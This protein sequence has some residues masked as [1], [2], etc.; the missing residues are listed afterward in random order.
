MRWQLDAPWFGGWSGIEVTDH[1]ARMTVISDFGYILNAS[2]N[3]ASG[4]LDG[5]A[6]QNVSR[7]GR[8]S[9]RPLRKKASDAEG[10]AIS[11]D[12]TAYVSFEHRHRIM[13]VDPDTG[14][15]SG[16][17]ALPFQNTLGDN[18]GVEALAISADGT[19]FAIAENPPASGG[20]FP[21]YAYRNGKWRISA[22]IPQRGPF[23]PV[24]A[25]FDDKGRYW[26]LERATTLL[27]FRSRIRMFVIDPRAPREVSLL[28]TLPGLY[29]NLEGLS[30]WTDPR[31]QM[32]VTMISDDNYLRI[33]RTQIVEYTVNE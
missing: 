11:D 4:K 5:V 23:V 26:L 29:D 20:S 1:G 13:Q 22:R 17:I 28:T 7:L 2:M 8:S 10:L 30:V 16:R 3:R 9:G 25:D 31:G 18:T 33:L 27:G 19:L 6:V 12:G 24:G 21:L 15:T 32:H 14:R